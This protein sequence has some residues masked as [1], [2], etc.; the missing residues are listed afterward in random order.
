MRVIVTTILVF[1]LAMGQIYA[2]NPDRQGEAGAGELLFNPWARSAGLHTLG[3]AS[4]KG[5]EA[6]RLNVAGLGRINRTELL[7]ANTRLF[8]GTDLKL[9]A[10]GFA[11]KLGEN[12]TFGISLTSVDFGEIPVTTTQQP[13]GTGGTFSPNFF[14]LGLGYSYTYA[15]KI[16]VGL[17]VRGVSES[18]ANVSAFGL[19]LDAGVQYVSGEKDNFKLGIS[20]R[21]IGSPMKFEGEGLSF[22][23][24]NP[25]TTGEFKITFDSRAEDFELPSVLNIGLSY[26]FYFSDDLI[27]IRGLANFTSNSFSQDQL[28]VGGELYFKDVVAIRAAFKKDIG[29]VNEGERNVY[30]GFAGG[31]SFNLPLNDE[32]DR[33]VG[34][35]YAY[36]T[37][38]PFEGTHNFSVRLT[39]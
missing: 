32:S 30:S 5:V 21:N 18:L 1:C 15:N 7:I 17:L 12:S 26:D 34:I 2:G 33:K 29:F 14:H 20:L 36:R 24:D 8:V 35:D 13:E 3:T 4:I 11:Q 37:T 6:M 9:N 25:G 10:V 19:A 28:G 22:E 38:D 31:I 27:M 23:V 16:S 39:L